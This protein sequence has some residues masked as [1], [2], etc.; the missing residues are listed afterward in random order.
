MKTALLE[1]LDEK[2]RTLLMAIAARLERNRLDR[3]RATRLKTRG[4]FAGRDVF[5]LTDRGWV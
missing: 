2:Q 5:A 4:S 1:T 3:V